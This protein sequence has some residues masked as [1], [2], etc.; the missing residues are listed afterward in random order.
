MQ[1]SDVTEIPGQSR[2]ALPDTS[3]PS[4]ATSEHHRRLGGPSNK[5]AGS[6]PA[7]VLKRA[8]GR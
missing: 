1:N 2:H 5:S 7:K 6:I 4:R 3:G 8:L